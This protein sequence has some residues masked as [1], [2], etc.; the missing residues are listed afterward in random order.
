[1]QPVEL[2]VEYKDILPCLLQI[3]AW[4]PEKLLSTISED[5]KLVFQKKRAFAKAIQV[6]IR[7]EVQELLADGIIKIIDFPECLSN[8]V[9]VPKP[10]DASC[11]CTDFTNLNKTIPNNPYPLSRVDQLVI[12][13]LVMSYF[14]SLMLIKGTIKS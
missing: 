9:V 10:E 7:K 6:V 2:L 1:M 4:C 11:V 13:L 3:W 14:P 12:P 8:P 5:T